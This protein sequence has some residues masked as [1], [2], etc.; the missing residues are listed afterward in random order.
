MPA[1]IELVSK[2]FY[3]KPFVNTVEPN[4]YGYRLTN[5]S[6]QESPPLNCVSG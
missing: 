5:A 4:R 3:R 2:F 1:N 6:A